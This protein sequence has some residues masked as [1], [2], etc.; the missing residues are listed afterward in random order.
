M[1]THDIRRRMGPALLLAAC[2]TEPADPTRST[3]N[4]TG[5]PEIDVPTDDGPYLDD[6]EEQ[7]PP[8]ID[9]AAIAAAVE[10]VLLLVSRADAGPIRDAY[11]SLLADQSG[12]CPTWTVAGTDTPYWF[13]AC[14]TESGTRFDGYAQSV[15]SEDRYDG[16]ILW[17]GW[18]FY[19]VATIERADGTLL[20]ASGAAGV[21]LGTQES[22][23][24]VSYTY[25]AE[26]FRFDGP[27]VE[28][29]WLGPTGSP[30]L[31]AWRTR[32]PEYGSNLVAIQARVRLDEGPVSVVVMDDIQAGNAASG[33]PCPDEPAGVISV[34]VENGTWVELYF[35]GLPFEQWSAGEVRDCDGCATAWTKGIEVG[36]VCV[37]TSALTSGDG[38][39]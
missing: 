4:A 16:Q 36:E 8:E 2:S 10:S 22:G 17:N 7:T 21:L 39:L 35:D 20:E 34:R 26:G 3:D 23:A 37:D 12:S 30:E 9:A 32:H 25:M 18:Q 5:L 38:A 31:T 27:G 33:S 6:P 24:I 29:D 11:D 14:T 28:P 15:L 1:P 19:G 13:D